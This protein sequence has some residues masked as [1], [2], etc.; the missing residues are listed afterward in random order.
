MGRVHLHPFFYGTV[1][2]SGPGIVTTQQPAEPRISVVVPVFNG[3]DCLDLCLRA[4]AESSLQPLEVIVV[5]DHS[6]DDSREIAERHGVTVLATGGRRG[7]AEARGL[8]VHHASGELIVFID[9]DVLVHRESLQQFAALF[10]Q[11]PD[12]AA[13]F[14]SYDDK[15]LAQNYLS[16]WKNL[17]H[18]FIHQNSRPDA[19]TFWAGCGAI[20]REVFL[21]IGG[22]DLR[23]R[24]AT[25]EDIEMGYRLTR[26]GF[27]VLLAK[28]IQATHT[29]RWDMRNLWRTDLL[30]RG[31]PWTRL[32]LRT[33]NLP[34]DLNVSWLQRLSLL[35]SMVLLAVLALTVVLLP[36]QAT[37]ALGVFLLVLTGQFWVS[38]VGF[39]R[40]AWN[41]LAVMLVTGVAVGLCAWIDSRWLAASILISTGTGILFRSRFRQRASQMENSL[42]ATALFLAIVGMVTSVPQHPL[43]VTAGILALGVLAIN[44]RYFGF[45][46]YKRGIP[47]A[48]AAFPFQILHHLVSATALA[49]G[50]WLH[51]R[52]GEAA[53]VTEPAMSRAASSGH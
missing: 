40:R 35:L 25:I 47:F 21:Q 28:D 27:R 34:N 11:R 4:L 36:L 3:G 16:Q 2:S 5:D 20:R 49:A 41:W 37:A 33:R 19:H 48:L 23:Y 32:I 6:T 46:A 50:M 51:Y 39:R 53:V 45:L 30:Y 43:A 10:Q 7:P 42:T 22:F 18:H 14:G 52:S 12:I 38:P 17:S 8:G 9:A 44:D 1:L 31:I 13:A 15:P 29:K 26:N 24:G